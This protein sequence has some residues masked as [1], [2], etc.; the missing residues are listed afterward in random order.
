MIPNNF[1]SLKYHNII[2]PIESISTIVGFNSTRN[3]AHY[4]N[5]VHA[6]L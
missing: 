6:H 1:Y 5:I 3:I 4:Y 2:I